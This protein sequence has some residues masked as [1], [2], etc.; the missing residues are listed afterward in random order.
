METTLS[1]DSL[2]EFVFGKS[3]RKI[4][5]GHG[6]EIGCG[7]VVPEINFTLPSMKC[8][9][10]TWPDVRKNYQEMIG[11]VLKR[12]VELESPSLLIEF[13]T[14]PDMTLNTAWGL[15]ICRLLADAIADCHAKHGLKNALRF[16]PNDTREFAR[17]PLMRQGKYWD[18]MQSIF[19][20]SAVA[21]ADIISIES[22]GGKEICDEALMAGDLSGILFALGVLAPRDMEFLWKAIV[23]S[24]RQHDI[25][26]GGDTACGFANTAMVLASQKMIPRV[27]AAVVRVASVPRSLVAY[28]VGAEGPSKDCAYEGPYLKAIA[29]VPI[30]MEGRSS[31][32][33]HFSPVGNISQA[34]CDC[35]SNES[36]QNVALLSG[37]APVVSVEQLIYDCRLME[38]ASK[39]SAD[40]RRLRDWLVASDSSTDPQAYVLR[41][42]VVLDISR[43]IIHEQS[44]Y[45]RTVASIRA[46]IEVINDADSNGELNL[47]KREKVWLDKLKLQADEFPQEEERF[48]DSM[49]PHIDPSRCHLEEYG[50]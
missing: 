27:L 29:G 2:D 23:G 10:Q 49:R 45:L 9:E 42:D 4:R 28:D 8:N 11:G 43:N 21:G 24:C 16:T 40:A 32:C 31:A 6:L 33:A 22:T 20:D 36:V 48:I 35:W 13:E 38:A 15:E 30:S 25:I 17:P 1:V 39:T 37:K 3:P 44:P 19:D 7:Q 12:A 26:P 46:A 41:P 34:V 18:D 50:L 14:V 5:C 47:S